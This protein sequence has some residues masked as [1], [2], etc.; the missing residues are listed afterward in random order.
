MA[1]RTIRIRR[2]DSPNNVNPK[3]HRPD[4]T[5]IPFWSRELYNVPVNEYYL[6][7]EVSQSVLIAL[8]REKKPL[9]PGYIL[10][11]DE[12]TYEGR[13]VSVFTR[14]ERVMSDVWEYVTKAI[15]YSPETLGQKMYNGQ[16]Q[17]SSFLEVV[18]HSTGHYLSYG[19]AEV[20]ASSHI[21]AQW[22]QE[23]EQQRKR[24]EAERLER[25][26][27]ARRS[28]VTVGKIVKVMKGRKV[29]KGTFGKVFWVGNNG[30]GTSVGIATT[31]KKEKGRYLDV[32]FTSIHNVQVV[33]AESDEAM[34]AAIAQWEATT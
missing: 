13:V 9:P 27:Q 15:V 4:G 30:Y 16:I 7:P 10:E 18:V 1:I 34:N 19:E 26:A 28:E 24:E 11:K 29:P 33:G 20:D 25:E 3:F 8:A 5:V 17:S 6:T 22:E 14:E 21:I 2:D 12:T 23:C 31:N 32:V